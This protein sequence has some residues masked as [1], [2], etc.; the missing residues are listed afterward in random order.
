[1]RLINTTTLELEE[2]PGLVPSYA[3]LSHTWGKEEVTLQDL[4]EAHK[5]RNILNLYSS[6]S[7]G[8]PRLTPSPGDA[9]STPL[10]TA[11]LGH[12][13]TWPSTSSPNQPHTPLG[14][15]KILHA[16]LRGQSDGLSYLWV[17]TCCI[18]KTSS[19]ELSEA[20]NSMYAWYR[21]S[22]VCYA[23]L[24][25]VPPLSPSGAPP[26]VI[27]SS[28]FRRSRWFK[29]GWTLQELLA[30]KFLT[31]FSSDWSEISTKQLLVPLIQEI[32]GIH[33]TYLLRTKHITSASVAERMSWVSDRTTTRP[34]DV[35]YCLLGVFDV[36][37]PLIYGE[38]ARAFVRLQ[39]EIIR[40]SE[41][42]SIFAW[43]WVGELS[44]PIMR[45]DRRNRSG[46]VAEWMRRE[47]RGGWKGKRGFP[48]NRLEG[49]MS[50]TLWADPL[51][52]TLLA[53]D[54]ICFYASGG[55]GVM[56]PRGEGGGPGEY[57]KGPGVDVRPFVM[58][59]VGLTI[60]LKLIRHVEGDL[61]FA[62]IHDDHR[63]GEVVAVPLVRHHEHRS[64]FTRTWFPP[65]P[66]RISGLAMDGRL[67]IKPRDVSVVRD[68]QHV[69]FYY[70]GGFGG[71][72]HRRGF[73]LMQWGEGRDGWKL[74]GGYAAAGAA[75]NS[76][77]VF[78]DLPD[79]GEEIGPV[80]GVLVFEDRRRRVIALLAASRD[81]RWRIPRPLC[82]G[83]GDRAG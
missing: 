59:N 11:P 37:M 26:H 51:R 79:D 15:Y 55:Y 42:H 77:G 34:E 65:G 63:S 30:P 10:R 41:D 78:F 57:E 61:V 68:V 60:R 67:L 14:F 32:T 54:P 52:C 38:G 31:F 36:H 72:E 43:T 29:R 71:S 76:Y 13:N 12:A 20:I 16:S 46:E 9:S 82:G 6:L 33:A 22:T 73:W 17:D 44:A 50:N 66:V 25:D 75:F 74:T 80:G 39:E 5:H 45:G 81:T 64:R 24:S 7:R 27:S 4:R 62:V 21:N 18:D 47:V 8:Y 23:Y 28:P 3:I 70:P 58:T 19:A 53:P 48:E 35:A 40:I 56:R 1:M 69:R 83:Y 2:F 49:L